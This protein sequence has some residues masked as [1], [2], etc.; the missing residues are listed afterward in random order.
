MAAPDID[1]QV[2]EIGAVV[3]RR[4][5]EIAQRVASSV[6]ANVAFYNDTS[7]VSVDEL[8]SSST[9]TSGSCSRV[10]ATV[11]PSIPRPPLPP[12]LTVP[13]P[14]CPFPQ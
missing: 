12:A 11:R 3:G 14:A 13:P 1:A 6:R 5:D 4:L 9:E 2:M 7:V 10:F 8:L